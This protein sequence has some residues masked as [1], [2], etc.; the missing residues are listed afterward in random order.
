MKEMW[1]DAMLEAFHETSRRLGL[2]LPKL[3]ALITFLV[4]GVVVGWLVKMLLMRVLSAVRF[5]AFCERM[6]LMPALARAGVV[7]PASS[8]IGRLGFWTVFLVFTLMGIDALSLP[9]TAN[10]MGVL[11][12]FLPNLLA[13]AFLRLC[14]IR[15][16]NFLGEAA[17]IAAVN[18]QIQEARLIAHFVR[19]GLYL[20]T[21][22]MVLTQLGIA[23]EI[24]V[25]AFCIMFGGIVLALAIAV[26]LGG[27]N[28]ARDKLERRL[29]R[30]RTEEDE[31][32]H[33]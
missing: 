17:L 14:G 29:H 3:L 32:T 6:G 28:I 7:Q 27:R 9:A 18:A 21:G 25:A 13:S 10:L 19:W 2:F 23:K 12:E 16:G 22:A 4:L 31:L 11:L 33:I 15:L 8:L 5:D 20:F 1:E 30:R 24:V 26:G